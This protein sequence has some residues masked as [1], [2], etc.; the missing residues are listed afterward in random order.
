MMFNRAGELV[1]DYLAE[2][3]PRVF[4]LIWPSVI[5]WFTETKETI[6]IKK[7]ECNSQSFSLEHQHG[8]RDVMWKHSIERFEMPPNHRL[9]VVCV[10]MSWAG[11]WNDLGDDIK[12][13][14]GLCESLWNMNFQFWFIYV[15]LRSKSNLLHFC[16]FWTLLLTFGAYL[17]LVTFAC[18]CNYVGMY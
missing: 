16:C 4:S 11:P 15:F 3:L 8:P 18:L 2:N 13:A 5:L 1:S 10:P 14:D 7:I 6:Y 9:A 17:L 12:S